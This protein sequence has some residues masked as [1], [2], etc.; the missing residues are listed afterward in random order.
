VVAVLV[1]FPGFGSEVAEEAS[2]VFDSTAP[3]VIEGSTATVNVNT[4]LATANDDVEHDTVPPAPTAGVVQDQPPGDDNETNVVP[5]GNI[6][7][8]LTLAD[9]LG[10]AFVVVIV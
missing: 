8:M 3:G 4:A 9:S 7:D 2:A 1:S 5:A 6:S 10:P